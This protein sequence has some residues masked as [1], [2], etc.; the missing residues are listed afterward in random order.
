[1]GLRLSEGV[2]LARVRALCTDLLDEARTHELIEQDLLAR[3][4]YRL[5]ATRQ[6]RPV[7][8]RLIAEIVTDPAASR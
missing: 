6:G 1:M 4:G 7:L 2:D 3:S 5:T 8:N